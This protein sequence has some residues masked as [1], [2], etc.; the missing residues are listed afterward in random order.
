MSITKASHLVF[1]FTLMLLLFVSL[2]HAAASKPITECPV[3]SIYQFGDSIAD[4]GNLIR[5]GPVGLRSHAASF[6]YG[7]TYFLMN[8]HYTNYKGP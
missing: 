5:N 4:T 3:Q 7:Q 8:S 6:P 2:A 1:N